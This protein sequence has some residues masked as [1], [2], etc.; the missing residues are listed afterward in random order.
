MC[1]PKCRCQ[2]CYEMHG[3][4]PMVTNKMNPT[5][6]PRTDDQFPW[7]AECPR[8][9]NYCDKHLRGYWK[10]VGSPWHG[11]IKEAFEIEQELIASQAEVERLKAERELYRAA[12]DDVKRIA[13]ERNKAEVEVDRLKEMVMDCAKRSDER[14][15]HLIERAEKAETLI[16]QIN[17]FVEALNPT[18]K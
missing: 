12:N 3:N 14:S 7:K 16:K 8:M 6:T 9:S 5:D 18:D 15:K 4:G 1:G 2:K 11:V 10:N 17:A 13:E